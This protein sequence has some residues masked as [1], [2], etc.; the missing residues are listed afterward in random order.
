MNV[1]GNIS[2]LLLTEDFVNE[3][4]D[5]MTGNLVMD[6]GSGTSPTL[7]FINQNDENFNIN[8][9]QNPVSQYCNLQCEDYFNFNQD[10]ITNK[11]VNTTS[12]HIEADTSADFLRYTDEVGNDFF[13][14]QKTVLPGTTVVRSGSICPLSPGND[15]LGSDS[16]Q[17][18]SVFVQANANITQGNIGS[19]T[20][21]VSAGG[22]VNSSGNMTANKYCFDPAFTECF[23]LVD[24]VINITNDVGVDGNIHLTGNLSMLN[25]SYIQVGD[26]EGLLIK[27][28]RI[29]AENGLGSNRGYFG[30]TKNWSSHFKSFDESFAVNKSG[31]DGEYNEQT[32]I[33]C[34]Y[35]YDGFTASDA[36]RP[37]KALILTNGSYISATAR[38]FAYI[39]SSCVLLNLNPAWDKNLTDVSWITRTGMIIN[40]NDGG[41][42]DF[43]VGTDEQA[44]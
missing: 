22:N 25:R 8:Y 3:T 27:E 33:F 16:C 39:N 10:I 29:L 11:Q 5:T 21:I 19:E 9:F 38:V 35:T 13:Q 42:Y 2:G 41:A 1:T 31:N 37:R 6:D 4:G 20:F 17:W 14:I 43:V 26:F 28:G 34:D 15:S 40:F 12:L 44:V 36:Q 23:G 24:G 30:I 32:N 18:R 7:N